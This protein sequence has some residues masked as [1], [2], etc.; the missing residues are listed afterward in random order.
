MVLETEHVMFS[1]KERD[2][3]LCASLS[4]IVSCYRIWS[5][6]G[7]P[8]HKAMTEYLRSSITYE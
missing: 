7:C 8:G 6:R 2:G 1:R 5:R 3:I 4:D